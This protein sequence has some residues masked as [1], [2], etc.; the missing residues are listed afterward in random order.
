[1]SASSQS[2]IL[3]DFA[4]S[5]RFE[6][7]PINVINAAK[8]CIIDTIGVCVFGSQLP[9]SK[10]IYAYAKSYGRGGQSQVI[11]Y[12]NSRLHAPHAALANGAFA[13]AFEQDS[14]RKPGAG[15][16]PGATLFP[17]A[18]A[19][20]QELNASG[21]T[22]LKSF[23]AGC[24]VL[25]RIGAAS[26]HS[27]EQL[28]FHAPG[29]TGVFGAAV[30][31]GLVQDLNSCKLANALGIAGSM[32]SGL[33]A[34]TKSKR[35]SEVKKLHLGKA[36]ES[37]ILASRLALEG[38][39]G[40]ETIFEGKFGFFEAFCKSSDPEVLT[41]N[42]G[43]DWET[44][45]ICLKT[46]PCHITVHPLIHSLYQMMNT[47]SFNSNDIQSCDLLVPEKVL[48]HHDNRVP[49]DVKQAQYSVPFC[50]AIAMDYDLLDPYIFN[51]AIINN[52]NVLNNCKKINMSAYSDKIKRTSW[53][54]TLK[55]LLKNGKVFTTE[56][57][58]FIGSPE[59][60][61]DTLQLKQRFLKH[62]QHCENGKAESWFN[63]FLDLEHLTSLNYLPDLN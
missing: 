9:W 16:H 2:E 56:S 52:I 50:L 58:H 7:I 43:V 62:T 11:G 10:K 23:I 54:S 53:T 12:A 18:F 14:L 25:F 8:F 19:L 35:G 33:L 47:Y 29:L 51:D 6:D 32:S 5:L 4:T 61:L 17:S 57:D 34:F 41:N 28:G 37:G 59:N 3:C 26:K 55:I 22:L 24:E 13:H 45:K 63:A 48:S 44:L 30:T 31:S 46:Y 1:M 38:F 42:L 39:E 15:V 40:P 20:S 60:P 21:E 49:K 36:C 27:S